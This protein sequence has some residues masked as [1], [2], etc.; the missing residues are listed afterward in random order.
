MQIGY[1]GYYSSVS[2]RT[3]Y[4]GRNDRLDC[5][6]TIDKNYEINNT[7]L[8][9]LPIDFISYSTL[10][11]SIVMNVFFYPN[12]R[13]ICSLECSPY[14]S[15]LWLFFMLLLCL[16]FYTFMAYSFFLFL[17]LTFLPRR[18]HQFTSYDYVPTVARRIC[19]FILVVVMKSTTAR[20]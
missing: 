5:L 4:W 17:R 10:L 20:T 7:F 8:A 3:Y 18:C 1:F 16:L 15:R 19:T 13:N 9:R 2:N 6:S 12:S 14:C 11:F